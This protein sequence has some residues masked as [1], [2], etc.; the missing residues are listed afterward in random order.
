MA[1][2]FDANSTLGA[3][4]IGV[5]VSYVL[6]G[7]TTTQLYIYSN[8]FPD[9]PPRVR[10]L[11]IFVWL[12]ELVHAISIGHTLYVTTI[13]DFGHPER[14]ARPPIS[15]PIALLFSG[16]VGASVQ[17]FF[18]HRIYKFTESLYI[19]CACWT[20]SSI[21]MGFTTASFV[22]ALRMVTLAAYEAQWGW[23]F[24][25]I[26]VLSAVVDV[27]IAATLVYYLYKRRS[28]AYRGT[29]AVMDKLIRWT[30]ETGVVTSAGGIITLICFLTLENTYIWLGCFAVLAR[31]FSN[32]LLAS[33]NARASL[34]PGA[35]NGLPYSD[36]LP[37][38]VQRIDID[39]KATE[40]LTQSSS[41]R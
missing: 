10:F 34:R 36:V 28:F 12:G 3:F 32:S 17:A 16:I 6:F 19:P 1:P 31:L 25:V 27:I 40:V 41:G 21:R 23:L 35:D 5:L 11:V 30:I 7:V 2:T 8:R 9:E 15:L 38:F 33:L 4:E 20:L 14:F 37:S 29:V 13:T 39:I 22:Y 18:A 26:L 24:Y